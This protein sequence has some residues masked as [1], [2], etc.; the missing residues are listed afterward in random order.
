MDRMNDQIV[1]SIH[2]SHDKPNWP[3]AV[4][5]WIQNA[6]WWG[7]WAFVAWLA[8]SIVHALAVLNWM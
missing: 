4:A 8:V 1:A 6:I 3:D 5:G 7:F 2:G